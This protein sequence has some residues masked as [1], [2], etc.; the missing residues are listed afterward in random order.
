MQ[1]PKFSRID[2]AL[3]NCLFS[4]WKV[5][6]ATVR[7]TGGYTTHQKLLISQYVSQIIEKKKTT[8]ARENRV[9]V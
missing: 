8:S 1:N 2:K 4:V 6:M 5:L 9:D 7:D 3:Y